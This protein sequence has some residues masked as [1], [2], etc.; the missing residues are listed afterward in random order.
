MKIERVQYRFG[1]L[2]GWVLAKEASPTIVGEE[3]P[4]AIWTAFEMADHLEACELVA[5]IGEIAD[6]HCVCPDIDVRQNIVFVTVKTA[7]LGLIEE[8][9]DFAEAIDCEIGNGQRATSLM[10]A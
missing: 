5:H 6:Q 3:V 1:K 9:F 2:D 10:A 8:D 4:K 7:D